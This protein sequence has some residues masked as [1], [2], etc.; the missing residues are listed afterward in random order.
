MWIGESSHCSI[1]FWRLEAFL[2]VR[3]QWPVNPA[4]SAA[5]INWEKNRLVVQ[6]S[7]GM[8]PMRDW[9]L[10]SPCR[11]RRM[12]IHV[13]PAYNINFTQKCK[14]V[15][16]CIQFLQISQH[17]YKNITANQDNSMHWSTCN[18]NVNLSTVCKI[19]NKTGA[20]DTSCCQ[21]DN[22]VKAIFKPY[23]SS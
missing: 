14:L 6:K 8:V 2:A 11:I 1:V 4:K 23:T 7:I 5:L 19:S 22:K 15:S 9:N 17:F 13:W 20:V 21:T 10:A 16:L 18:A 12:L 3:I